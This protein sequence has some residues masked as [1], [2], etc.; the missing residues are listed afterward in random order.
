MTALLTDPAP[1]WRVLESI[2]DP[3]FGI[4]IVDLGLIYSVE[5][6]DGDV[7]IVMTLTT[8]TC[9]AGGWIHEG[10]RTAVGKLQ[11]TKR[12][13]VDLVFDPAWN[14]DMLS[15]AAREELGWKP[16]GVS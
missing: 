1:I 16:K 5:C 2:P 9:P 14:A 8:P 11:G 10:V 4:N 13:Q 6:A 3:E 7:K 15:D 12:V